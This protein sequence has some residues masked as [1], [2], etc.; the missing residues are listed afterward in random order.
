MKKTHTLLGGGQT[1]E[2]AVREEVD[3]NRVPLLTWAT[4]PKKILLGGAQLLK[5]FKIQIQE[6]HLRTSGCL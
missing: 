4:T 1:N 5:Y 2:Q 3:V 6:I